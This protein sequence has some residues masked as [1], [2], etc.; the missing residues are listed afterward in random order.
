MFYEDK[1]G[2]G[3]QNDT[4]IHSA[5]A[6]VITQTLGTGVQPRSQ[7]LPSLSPLVVGRKTLV[8]G[9]HVTTKIWVV[10][11][12]VGWE[13]WQSALFV[14]VPNLVGFKTSISS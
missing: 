5:H 14:A 10:K 9:G 3:T 7:S 2:Y 12:S 6:Y 4:I 8:A 13:G 11:K 1:N